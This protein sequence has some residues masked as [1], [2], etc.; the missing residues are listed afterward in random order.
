MNGVDVSGSQEAAF[1]QLST[2]D[3]PIIVEVRRKKIS[4]LSEV[5]KMREETENCT[6]PAG[7]GVD[8]IPDLEYEVK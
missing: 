6:L 3:E 1:A 7:G 5:E 2:A 8:I 4:E